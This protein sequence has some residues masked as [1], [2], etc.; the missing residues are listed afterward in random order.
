MP[1]ED[2]RRIQISWLRGGHFPAM[3]FNGQMSF[4]VELTLR[5]T[6]Q[7]VRLCR[8]PVREL[9]MLHRRTLRWDAPPA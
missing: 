3:P 4:P 2:G 8:Q 5:T 7:G 9:E 1:A 6:P